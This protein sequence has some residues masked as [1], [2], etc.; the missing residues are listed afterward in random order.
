MRANQT[1]LATMKS[2]FVSLEEEKRKKREKKRRALNRRLVV[3][4][5]LFAIALSSVIY[6][7]I[8]KEKAYN[9]KLAQQQQLEAEYQALQEEETELSQEIVNLNS[10][11]Y[12]G[13][14]ARKE[15]YLSKP[16][17]TIFT[18]PDDTASGSTTSAETGQAQEETQPKAGNE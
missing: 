4:M 8:S 16:G 3:I 1:K 14:L 12:I 6:L 9:K 18:I 7:K 2:D 13:K 5:V 10:E 17:E 11:E 15:Y